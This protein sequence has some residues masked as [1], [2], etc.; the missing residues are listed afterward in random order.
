MAFKMKY[1]GSALKK[2][3]GFFS[4]TWNELKETFRTGKDSAERRNQGRKH[5]HLMNPRNKSKEA[6]NYRKKNKA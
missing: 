4:T 2:K 1:Q 6:I 5:A 3:G